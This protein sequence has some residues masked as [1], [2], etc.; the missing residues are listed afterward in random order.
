MFEVGEKGGGAAV[1]TSRAH[2]LLNFFF[3]CMCH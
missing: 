3:V 1:I 2:A